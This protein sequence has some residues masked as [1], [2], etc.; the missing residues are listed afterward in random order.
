MIYKGIFILYCIIISFSG[1]GQESLS[2][3]PAIRIALVSNHIEEQELLAI[4]KLLQ[5]KTN[6]TYTLRDLKEIKN[7]DL[8]NRFTH[9]WYH[10]TDT[11]PFE[12]I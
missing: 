6:W 1:I 12:K 8:F 3:K 4:E 2:N 9:I 10:R 7:E 5:S 11:V